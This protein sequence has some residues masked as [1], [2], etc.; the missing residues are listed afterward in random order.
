MPQIAENTETA[1]ANEALS[2]CKAAKLLSLDADSTDKAKVLRKHFAIT[3][4]ALQRLYL[5]NFNEGYVSLPEGGAAIPPGFPFEHRFPLTADILRV[6]EVIGCS[7]REW[8]VQGRSVLANTAGPLK[9]IVSLREENVGV[10][11]PLF[12]ATMVAALAFAIAPE[13]ATDE[14]TIDRMRIAS[15]AALAKATPV[16]AGEGIP[17]QPDTFD[18]ISER[19]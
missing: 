7:K 19:F 4:D 3:R 1:V 15:E 14:E 5:W 8:K 16:D 11:D 6:R 9:A 12:R 18:V 17:D 10:W 13:I 2:A